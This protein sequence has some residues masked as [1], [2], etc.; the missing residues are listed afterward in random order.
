[1]VQRVLLLF[2]RILATLDDLLHCEPQQREFAVQHRRRPVPFAG[3]HGK[4][5]PQ[6]PHGLAKRVVLLLHI[7]PNPG[8]KRFPL[9]FPQGLENLPGAEAE[10]KALAGHFRQRV[11]FV[12]HNAIELRQ[13]PVGAVI[14]ELQVRHQHMVIHHHDL[15]ARRS[16]AGAKH[17]A[18]LEIR[19]FPAQAV[20]ASRSDAPGDQG[21]FR[22]SLTLRQIAGYRVFGPGLNAGEVGA[23]PV[24]EFAGALADA[25]QAVAAQV[26]GTPLEHADLHRTAQRPARQRQVAQEQL[27]LQVA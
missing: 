20:V 9:H 27:V 12:H 14:L 22:D 23:F 11:R 8:G 5:Q 13:Q 17:V 2:R 3:L 26:V 19:A 1:M 25:F 7:L 18:A 16:L 6:V 21:V 15:R 4:G 10:R 24:R